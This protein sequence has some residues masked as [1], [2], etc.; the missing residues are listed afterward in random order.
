MELFDRHKALAENMEGAA[1]A[2][3]ALRYGISAL[4]LRGI[5]NMVGKRDTSK[6]EI[7]PAATNCQMALMNLLKEL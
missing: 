5:S 6:W 1:V 4:E 2:H 7:K 3:I